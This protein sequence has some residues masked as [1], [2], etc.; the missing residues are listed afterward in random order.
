[1]VRFGFAKLPAETS[2]LSVYGLALLTG[3]GFTM[4]L[5]IG[6]LAFE[7]G[8]FNHLAA[9]RIGVFVGSLVS[10]VAGLLVLRIALAGRGSE[11]RPNFG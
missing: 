4:S 3:I 6:S 9:T 11:M 10:A 2:W 5:F 7:H 1:M 8:G